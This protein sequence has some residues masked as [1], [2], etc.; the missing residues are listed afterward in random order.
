MGDDISAA[1]IERDRLRYVWRQMLQRCRKTNDPSFDRYGGR[2]IKV[3]ARWEA[4]FLHFARDM[5]PRPRG[6]VLDRIDNDGNYEPGNCRWTTR[7]ISTANRSCSIWVSDG[8]DRIILSE[9]CRR[10]GLN[11]RT[12]L[13][14]LNHGV[15]IERAVD[16][17]PM[18]GATRLG[19]LTQADHANIRAMVLAGK[20]QS[21]VAR[22]FNVDPSMISHICRGRTRRTSKAS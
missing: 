19:K 5:G 7:E 14:R 22:S 12:V 6:Y 20:L 1:R 16:P 9:Y 15:S 21:E 3:C 13:N 4:S 11:Y 18:P 17:S 2:G 10:K 8:P